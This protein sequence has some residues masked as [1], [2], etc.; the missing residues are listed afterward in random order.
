M[1]LD[2]QGSL[3]TASPPMTSVTEA[4]TPAVGA[5]RADIRQ[6]E[7]C[8]MCSTGEV[9]AGEMGPLIGRICDHVLL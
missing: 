7:A 1:S 6:P 5:V 9:N 2:H 3:C 4:H 8:A